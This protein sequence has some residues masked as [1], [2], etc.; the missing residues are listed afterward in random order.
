MEVRLISRGHGADRC[1]PADWFSARFPDLS[2]Q[3]PNICRFL[4]EEDRVIR[5]IEEN[6]LLHEVEVYLKVEAEQARLRLEVIVPPEVVP[7]EHRSY[8]FAY[9]ISLVIV[10]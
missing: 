4:L 1:R 3:F 5:K 8:L 9:G 10:I 7:P 6:R 2:G